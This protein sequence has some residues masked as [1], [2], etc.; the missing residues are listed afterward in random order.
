MCVRAWCCVAELVNKCF[1]VT[2][3]SG[4]ENE[5]F[6]LRRWRWAVKSIFRFAV[7]LFDPFARHFYF[8]FPY[9]EDGGLTGL[10]FYVCRM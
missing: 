4:K 7:S 8:L 2:V 6:G 5:T 3:V 1:F 9:V 10:E